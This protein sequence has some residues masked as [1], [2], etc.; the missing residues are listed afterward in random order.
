MARKKKSKKKA[1][2]EAKSVDAE[3][4]TEAA[5][6]E[7]SPPSKKKSE[8]KRKSPKKKRARKKAAKKQ[9]GDADEPA[10]PKGKTGK[11]G[12][13]KKGKKAKAEE[14]ATAD[15]TVLDEEPSPEP[16]AAKPE[17]PATEV[18]APAPTDDATS[19]DEATE[20]E[21]LDAVIDDDLDDS[22]DL[23]ALIAATVAGAA[24]EDHPDEVPVQSLDEEKLDDE[25]V[26]VLDIEADE[27]EPVPYSEATDAAAE[28]QEAGPATE[29]Q[30]ETVKE[31]PPP[32]TEEE[33]AGAIDLGD[34]STPEVRDR[35]LAQALAHAEMQD[36]RYRVPFSDPGR[37]GRWKA[38]LATI[39]FLAAAVLA[40]AP[41][42]W[43]RPE[44]PAQLDAAGRARSVRRAL[45]LQAQQVDAYKVRVQRLPNSLEELPSR[46]DG[47][48]YVRS[49][50]GA[51]Q[52]I[53]YTTDGTIVYDSSNP[54]PEF[55][56]LARSWSVGGAR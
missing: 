25:P 55:E 37:A 4:S 18:E 35:I 41:P 21:D 53:A 56:R 30:S 39:L 28:A 31:E 52:L 1:E 29:E 54:S 20:I 48:R 14:P 47:V 36:A 33:L 6:S 43:V 8:P 9:A 19:E 49:G 5:T 34:V 16:D 32:S 17:E 23:D 44:P 51:F 45:L 15:A 27:D 50:N 22:E 24:P 12:A 38:G 7:T 11:A 3:D 10:K 13:K 42:A 26:E 2:P 46:L 40:V